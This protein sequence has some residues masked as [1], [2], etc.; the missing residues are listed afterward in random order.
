MSRHRRL[1]PDAGG[2]PGLRAVF[3]HWQWDAFPQLLEVGAIANELRA[4]RKAGLLYRDV[5]L[6]PRAGRQSLRDIR[7]SG[8]S[9]R[10][11]RVGPR[12]Y[13]VELF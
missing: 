7:G 1:R 6:R 13:A 3:W 4:A 12:Y 8:T 9:A 5:E 11:E 10:R 2:G